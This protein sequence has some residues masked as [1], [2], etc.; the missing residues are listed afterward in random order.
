MAIITTFPSARRKKLKRKEREEWKKNEERVESG[1][2]VSHEA[3]AE[4]GVFLKAGTFRRSIDW[5]RVGRNCR[6]A[7]TSHPRFLFSRQHQLTRRSFQGRDYH[8]IGSDLRALYTNPATATE[9][10]H[11][12]PASSL[13]PRFYPGHQVPRMRATHTFTHLS[14]CSS[15][16]QGNLFFIM[17]P[18]S[19]KLRAIFSQW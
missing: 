7:R 14:N 1:S 15:H 11:L 5:Q 3:R 9:R 18:T 6:Q 2:Y 19:T 10:L 12:P 17:D 13:F 16:S 8:F 4:C